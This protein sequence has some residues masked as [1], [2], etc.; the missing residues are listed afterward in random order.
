MGKEVR[1]TFTARQTLHRTPEASRKGTHTHTRISTKMLIHPI[2]I[3]SVGAVEYGQTRE[4]RKMKFYDDTRA[5][6]PGPVSSW[7]ASCSR[8]IGFC[9]CVMPV[10]CSCL[11]D[12]FGPFA[13]I[14]PR[15]TAFSLSLKHTRTDKLV[16]SFASGYK[17]DISSSFSCFLRS[18][19][20]L[21]Q[22]IF[23]L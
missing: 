23:S 2:P 6:L 10:Q 7:R 3:L 13:G 20:V 9:F 19:L 18:T 14:Q 12:V 16:L 15:G 21:L 5:R 22:E 11:S 8:Y 17:E 1:P 4:R